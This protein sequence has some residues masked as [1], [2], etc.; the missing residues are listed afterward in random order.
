MILI[1]I[2]EVRDG[3]A[4]IREMKKG[5]Q[6]KVPLDMVIPEMIKRIGEENLDKYSP[7]E[8]LG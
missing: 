4:I 3:V 5:T 2:T 1:G 8:L 7:G 6:K